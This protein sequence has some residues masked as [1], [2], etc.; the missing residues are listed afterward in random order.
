MPLNVLVLGFA[1]ATT[2]VTK[3]PDRPMASSTHED[4]SHPRHR[5]GLGV[6]AATRDPAVPTN[7]A[8]DPVGTLD[9]YVTLYAM[10]GMQNRRGPHLQIRSR[11]SGD[12][13]GT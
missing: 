3:R 10:E 4:G 9:L 2:A 12:W 5:P 11:G 7:L 13:H 6:G 1:L 8:S